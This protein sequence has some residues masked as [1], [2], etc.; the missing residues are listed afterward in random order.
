MTDRSVRE[1]VEL[2]RKHNEWRRGCEGDM[3][4]PMEIGEAIESVCDSAISASEL[5][6]CL[7]ETLAVLHASMYSGLTTMDDQN[8]ARRVVDRASD[9]LAKTGGGL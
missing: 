4:H 9:A 7:S 1:Q 6:E 3:A 5:R 8:N 2:L